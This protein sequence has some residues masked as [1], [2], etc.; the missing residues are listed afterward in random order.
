MSSNDSYLNLIKPAPSQHHQPAHITYDFCLFIFLIMKFSIIFLLG[1]VS[2]S[3][4]LETNID[5]NG[6][7]IWGVSQVYLAMRQSANA[8]SQ[9]FIT[10]RLLIELAM[11]GQ[12]RRVQVSIL[13]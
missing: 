4:A 12:R 3:V 2:G 13:C 10:Q 11:R 6:P 5:P 9:D 7:I 8:E 1:L